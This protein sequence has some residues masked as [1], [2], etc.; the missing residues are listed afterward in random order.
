MHIKSFLENSY[1]SVM[2]VPLLLN[3]NIKHISPRYFKTFGALLD[4]RSK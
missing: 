4:E 1:S 3:L 2:F